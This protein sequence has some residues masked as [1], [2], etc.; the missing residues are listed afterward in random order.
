MPNYGDDA[1]RHDDAL[2][3]PFWQAKKPSYWR[4][5][6]NHDYSGRYIYFITVVRR[7]GLP[8]FGRITTSF[9]EKPE[10]A[11]CKLSDFG[12]IIKDALKEMPVRQPKVRIMQSMIMPD[13][14]HLMLYFTEKGALSLGEWV[15]SFKT[16]VNRLYWEKILRS[17]GKEKIQVF[18]SNF[19]DRIIRDRRHLAVESK[20]MLENPRRLFM[21][22]N[23]RD[24]FRVCGRIRVGERDYALFGNPL[25]IMKP[26]ILAVKVS[27]KDSE[28]TKVENRRRWLYE[29]ARD[30]V[31]ASPFINPKEYE[32]YSEAAKMGADIILIRDNGFNNR[33]KPDGRYF[34]HCA[35]GHLLIVGEM[36]VHFDKTPDFRAKCLQMNATASALAAGDFEIIELRAAKL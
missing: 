36:E 28:Q 16:L 15:G 35:A 11:W 22:I 24:Y 23:C 14:L 19:H 29:A 13:H 34:D 4:R 20:Y 5:S 12:L 6:F 1:R 7:S 17:D 33:F 3:P 32:I 9:E 30:T 2:L 26:N 18:I 21:K 25:I 10:N 31:L 8:D 27:R